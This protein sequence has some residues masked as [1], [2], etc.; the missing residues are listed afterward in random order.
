MGGSVWFFCAI[1]K[2][3]CQSRY[4]LEFQ[5]SFRICSFC[6]AWK[7]T[8]GWN[9]FERCV[10]LDGVFLRGFFLA[11]VFFD[12]DFD[13][14]RDVTVLKRFCKSQIRIWGNCVCTIFFG[15]KEAFKF[16]KKDHGWEGR[17]KFAKQ[18][19]YFSLLKWILLL[20][21]LFFFFEVEAWRKNKMSALW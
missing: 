17:M 19:G 6:M 4:L 9:A 15:Y 11:S 21:K 7:G 18:G 10:F 2:C 5:Q 3:S 20:K 12:V 8:S 13:I 14:L 1:S 16:L